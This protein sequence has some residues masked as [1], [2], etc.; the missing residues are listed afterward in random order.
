M[1]S[2]NTNSKTGRTEPQS[3]HKVEQ[4]EI[5]NGLR[6]EWVFIPEQHIDTYIQQLEGKSTKV[7]L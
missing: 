2:T 1:K 6:V 5:I 4:E 7:K 3:E